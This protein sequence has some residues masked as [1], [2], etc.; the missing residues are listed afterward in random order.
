MSRR[1]P[2]ERLPAQV[3]RWVSDHSRLD[4]GQIVEVLPEDLAEALLPLPLEDEAVLPPVGSYALRKDRLCVGRCSVSG[5]ADE[6]AL[7]PIWEVAYGQACLATGLPLLA[8]LHRMVAGLDY[9]AGTIAKGYLWQVG[10]SRLTPLHRPKRVGIVTIDG[11]AKVV[12]E[13]STHHMDIGGLL[14]EEHPETIRSS[15]QLIGVEG[16]DPL[17]SPF[18]RLLGK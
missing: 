2:F 13:R 3:G 7:A 1:S 17:G 6:L 14:V 4:R 8:D 12:G 9:H 10:W 11:G 5:L 15:P 16:D 18:C